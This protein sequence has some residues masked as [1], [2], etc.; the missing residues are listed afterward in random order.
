MPS[1]SPE[2]AVRRVV[3]NLKTECRSMLDQF[4]AGVAAYQAKTKKQVATEKRVA[5]EASVFDEDAMDEDDAM[6]DD[7]MSERGQDTRQKEDLR[8]EELEKHGHTS[9]YSPEP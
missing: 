8:L 4:D 3:A 5:P 1:S 6:Q 9:E 7:S 2:A